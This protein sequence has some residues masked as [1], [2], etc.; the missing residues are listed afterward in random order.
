MFVALHVKLK[1]EFMQACGFCLKHLNIC[2]NSNIISN[3]SQTI[4]TIRSR[5]R[6]NSRWLR[7]DIRVHICTHVARFS[8]NPSVP[9]LA[10]F[11]P[12]LN[13]TFQPSFLRKAPSAGY[14]AVAMLGL[15]GQDYCFRLAC[16]R[17]ARICFRGHT[18]TVNTLPAF[19]HIHIVLHLSLSSGYVVYNAVA[20]NEVQVFSCVCDP[21]H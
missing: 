20:V 7:C 13:S 9:P 16:A 2:N 3:R 1:H 10:R 19:W 15:Q 8:P 5:T 21:E 4:F 18:L 14:V 11:I 17:R 12:P 6:T